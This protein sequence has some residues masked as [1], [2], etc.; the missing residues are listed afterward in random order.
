MFFIVPVI[1]YDKFIHVSRWGNLGL[2]S[3]CACVY[4]RRYMGKVGVWRSGWGSVGVSW[5]R[6][7]PLVFSLYSSISFFPPFPSWCLPPLPRCWSEVPL[8]ITSHAF[9][10]PPRTVEYQS[11]FPYL[12]FLWP[13][14]VVKDNPLK[15]GASDHIYKTAESF[16]PF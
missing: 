6:P 11:I 2:L 13:L 7:L 9:S 16:L 14:Q 5:G 10:Q 15:C 12:P 8:H 3:A 1:K 4:A